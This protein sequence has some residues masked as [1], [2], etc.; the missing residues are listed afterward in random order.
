MNLLKS[1]P[2]SLIFALILIGSSLFLSGCTLVQE[3]LTSY[4]SLVREGDQM[5]EQ[6]EYAKAL[7]SYSEAADLAPSQSDAFFGIVKILVDKGQLGEASEIIEQS[8]GKISSQ[9][10][11]KLHETLGQAYLKINDLVNAEKQYLSANNTDKNNSSVKVGLA[12]VYIKSGK[13]DKAGSYLDI[14]QG[15]DDYSKA[16]I[17]KAFLKLDN[18]G[19]AK[20][21]IS[22]LDSSS[23]SEEMNEIFESFLSALNKAGSDKLYNGALLARE[24]I[25]AGYP[26]L[27]IK[28]L[29]PHKEEMS[30]Y[31]DG[32][33]FL[34]RAYYDYGQYGSAIKTLQEATSFGFY[35]GEIYTLLAKAHYINDMHNEAFEYFDRAL[36]FA[37]VEEKEKI[38]KEYVEMLIAQEQYTRVLTL[39]SDED[40]SYWVSIKNAQVYYAQRNYEKMR[41]HIE[42]IDESKLTDEEKKEY[43][44][45]LITYEIENDSGDEA[46]ENLTLLRSLDMYNPNYYFLLGRLELSQNNQEDGK[47]ALERAIEYDLNGVVTQEAKRVLARID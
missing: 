45:W 8:A 44:K 25:N 20:S 17:I 47:A 35:T 42:E 46:R 12:Q 40:S 7:K 28:I 32:L 31:A 2:K 14:G 41:F 5:Y 27:A 22:N 21:E 9:D 11:A 19:A 26:Y 1:F 30:E 24:Y 16:A 37:Q 34:G 38:L 3:D 23:V 43:L 29:D 4:A 13:L 39:L 10:K 18:I 15:E 6:R 36:T 33:Y